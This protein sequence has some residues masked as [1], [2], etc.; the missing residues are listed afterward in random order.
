MQKI[1]IDFFST[2]LNMRTR[3]VL[4]MPEFAELQGKLPVVYCLHGLTGNCDDWPNNT[5]IMGKLREYP[6]IY[7][8]PS[9]HN[10]FYCNMHYG[11]N[12]FEHI[13]FELPSYIESM[14]PIDTA[15][16]Y[17]CGLSMGG[18]G[19]LKIA[20]RNPER[21]AACGSFSGV[22]DIERASREPLFPSEMKACFGEQLQVPAEENCFALAKNKACAKLPVYIACGTE[23]FLFLD[24]EHF[25]A[26]NPQL[27]IHYVKESGDHDWFFWERHLF[28]F[29]QMYVGKNNGK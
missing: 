4:C 17:I 24:N 8:F 15:R 14:Y 21:F 9:A 12:F 11:Q 20:L 13:A 22:L 3:V 1:Q 27:N 6:A 29:V 26:Q 25:V 2:I 19:A 16:R 28:A 7:V 5:A 10:S 18:Y 23:D